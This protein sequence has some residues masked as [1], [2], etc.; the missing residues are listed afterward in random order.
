MKALKAICA[1]L[2]LSGCAMLTAEAPLFSTADQDGVFALSTGLWAHREDDCTL[3]PAGSSPEK[4]DCI[5][6][7]RSGQALVTDR[8][9]PDECQA[10]PTVVRLGDRYHM[11]FCYR[12]ATDFRTNPARG[13]RIGHA[14]S[15][16]IVSWQR[17]DD[18]GGLGASPAGWD[19]EML[20]YPHVFRHAGR[21][22]MLYNGNE[23]GRCGFGL[24]V[25][26]GEA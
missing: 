18:E 4:K 11:W 26:E 2:A 24:A 10:L 14:S 21:L 8:L 13:Y 5:D 23:F 19:S 22:Y 12:H 15:A 16:D 1:A 20:C 3:D 17:D 6:W 25:L 9:G 7:A